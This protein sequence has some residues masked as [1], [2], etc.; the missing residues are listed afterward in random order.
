M[1]RAEKLKA[2]LDEQDRRQQQ[3][4]AADDLGSFAMQNKVR[5]WPLNCLF[6]L[7]PFLLLICGIL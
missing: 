1:I 4:A 6:I 3:V 2:F 5:V 7:H